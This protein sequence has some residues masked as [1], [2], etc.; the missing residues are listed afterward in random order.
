MTRLAAHESGAPLFLLGSGRC[1][2]TFWQTLLCRTPD[3]W[4][5]GEH[6]GFLN[7]LL[8]ARRQFAAAGHLLA[9]GREAITTTGLIQP[10]KLVETDLGWAL[11]WASM[12]T[13]DDF[14]DL[15]RGFIDAF[16]R[17]GLPEGRS[18][19]GFKEIRY[20]M[21][22]DTTPRTL[23]ELFPG[24]TVVHTLR[25]PR[26]SI[27]SALRAWNRDLLGQAAEAPDA[28][29]T[30]YDA[31][32]A[33]WLDVTTTLVELSESQPDRVVTVR[34]EDIPA[35]RGALEQRLGA[36]LPDD[37]P[38]INDIA[39]DL[40]EAAAAVLETAW[41]DWWPRLQPLAARAG[42]D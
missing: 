1:G 14:D 41:G 5:W 12:A 15:L 33:R 38:R 13:L 34:L 8:G 27:E 22:N 39:R 26:A 36:P 9:R 40:D 30:A 11:A 29:R 31:K 18:R 21:R 24:G 2:S 35:G 10:E 20:G 32:A 6:G 3:T 25:H 7:P 37:H 16:M 17:Q 19:W 42:Y 4:I 28:I 23:L